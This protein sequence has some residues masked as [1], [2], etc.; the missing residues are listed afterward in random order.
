MTRFFF[1]VVCLVFV[2]ISLACPTGGASGIGAMCKPPYAPGVIP[3]LP[4]TYSHLTL[5]GKLIRRRNFGKRRTSRHY[6]KFNFVHKRRPKKSNKK[7]KGKLPKSTGSHGQVNHQLNNAAGGV[8]TG[9]FLSQNSH[10]R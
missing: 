6:K 5:G 3:G 7:V 4:M 1:F 9:N 10:F 8:I 2:S